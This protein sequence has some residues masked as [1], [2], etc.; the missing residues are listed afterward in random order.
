MTE[1]DDQALLQAYVRSR[2]DAAMTQLVQRHINLVYSAALRQVNDPHSAEDVTQITFISLARH[3]RNLVGERVLS[4]WLLVTARN[5]AL[6]AVKARA[7]RT[8][9]EREAAQMAEQIRDNPRDSQWE[10]IAPHLDAALASLGV[11]DRRAVTLR[12]FEGCSSEEIVRRLGVSC[13]VA[14]QR[15]HRATVKMRNYFV[16]RGLNVSALSIGPAITSH[17]VG[18]APPA[19]AAATVKAVSAG[20]KTAAAGTSAT[21]V[22]VAL[23]LASKAKAAVACMAVLLVVGGAAATVAHIVQESHTTIPAA[24]E[25]APVSTVIGYA[26][27]PDGEP[28]AG[29]EVLVS[30]KNHYIRILHGSTWKNGEP[31]TAV[32]G[33]RV[34][35]VGK[36]MYFRTRSVD[37]AMPARSVTGWREETNA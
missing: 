24:E 20:M 33:G 12:Y 26:R 25:R 37:G 2:S 17:A 7:R 28:V 1:L 22:V 14:R 4:A 18:S 35:E 36:N 6:D 31:R 23:V 3:A 9:H 5:A 34:V 13:D 21:K 16:R 15:V 8:R 10:A 11:Q 19:L 27:T 32:R 29:A 30:T